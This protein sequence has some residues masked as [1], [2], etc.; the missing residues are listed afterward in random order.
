M[1]IRAE[2]VREEEGFVSFTHNT[3]SPHTASP[4][5]RV[6]FVC[7]RAKKKIL[8]IVEKGT[9]VLKKRLGLLSSKNLS[10]LVI[11]VII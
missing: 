2:L 5:Y 10:L 4:P 3:P 7:T 6:F 8:V 9:V 1:N 11:L